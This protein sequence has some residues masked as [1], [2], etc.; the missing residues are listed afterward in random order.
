MYP[1]ILLGTN[2]QGNIEGAESYHGGYWCNYANHNY[3]RMDENIPKA[4]TLME[5]LTNGRFFHGMPFIRMALNN[6]S[7]FKK[8]VKE[9]NQKKRKASDEEKAEID[10]KIDGINDEMSKS[11]AGVG[12]AFIKAVARY[13]RYIFK[14][15]KGVGL[16]SQQVSPT[17]I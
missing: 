12:N 16:Q 1:L 2:R 8:D 15:L 14:D 4:V 13:L 11:R 9:L 5:H 7:K 10:E 6:V 3:L 17:F